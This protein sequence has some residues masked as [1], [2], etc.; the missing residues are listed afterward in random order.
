MWLRSIGMTVL[1][2]CI[3]A[4]SNYIKRDFVTLFTDYMFQGSN[5][6]IEDLVS[7]PYQAVEQTEQ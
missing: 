4:V 1:R 7:D 3:F 5:F 2:R 6:I